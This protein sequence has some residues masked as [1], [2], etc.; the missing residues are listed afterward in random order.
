MYDKQGIKMGKKM[1]K[2]SVKR[3][4]KLNDFFHKV[5]RVIA[6]IRRLLEDGIIKK[7]NHYG[8]TQLY[9][10]ITVN[11]IRNR[12]LLPLLKKSN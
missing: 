6:K 4:R 8:K 3:E 11:Y 1:R 7:T 2:L 9:A 5:S 10:G 12:C